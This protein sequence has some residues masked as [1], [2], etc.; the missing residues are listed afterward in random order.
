MATAPHTLRARLLPE[1]VRDR[2]RGLRRHLPVPL[3]RQV[4]LRL[5][6]TPAAPTPGELAQGMRLPPPPGDPVRLWIAPAN[7][8]GQGHAWARAVD[9][10]VPGAGARCMAVEGVLGFPADQVVPPA[11][12]RDIGWQRAQERYVLGH[13]THVL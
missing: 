9:A 3:V 11:A 12:Y 7:F 2:V 4:D 13:Y 5:G 8:A 6:A 1:S 10:H